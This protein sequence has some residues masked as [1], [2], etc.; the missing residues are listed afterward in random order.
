MGWLWTGW[1][2]P[3][4]VQMNR[5]CLVVTLSWLYK[6]LL[7]GLVVFHWPFVSPWTVTLVILWLGFLRACPLRLWYTVTFTPIF[8]QLRKGPLWS[9]AKLLQNYVLC[10]SDQ[11]WTVKLR[12]PAVCELFWGMLGRGD[13]GWRGIGVSESG[14]NE[15]LALEVWNVVW[16][17]WKKETCKASCVCNSSSHVR[18]CVVVSGVLACVHMYICVCVYIYVYVCMCADM[19]L[20]IY[21]H[22]CMYMYMYAFI[23]MCMCMRMHICA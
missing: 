10:S 20:C 13:G 8:L 12:L 4:L 18:C 5:C 21:M 16:L 15:V 6:W 19:Y 22:V 9:C 3:A 1:T 17:C 23:H 2:S 11:C 7:Q 14:Y